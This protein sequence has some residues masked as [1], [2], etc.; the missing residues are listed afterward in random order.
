MPNR[1]LLLLALLMSLG[2]ATSAMAQAGGDPAAGK[3]KSSMCAGCHDTP[4]WRSIYP[5]YREPMLGGQHAEY[6]TAALKAY[7]SG[8]REHATMHAIAASLTDQDIADL[9]AY[10]SSHTD[11]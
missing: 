11:K 6:I 4:G 10:Y 5:N 8:T 1:Q 7:Q 2:Q 3:S 9:A